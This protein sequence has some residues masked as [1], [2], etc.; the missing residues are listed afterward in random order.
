MCIGG[1]AQI[2]GLNLGMKR[3]MYEGRLIGLVLWSLKYR[4]INN[5]LIQTCLI[6]SE[7]DRDD[8]E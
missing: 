6:Q 3:L 4:E 5:Y 2:I 1:N 7:T 8:G